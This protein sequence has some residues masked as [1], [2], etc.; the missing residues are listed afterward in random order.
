MRWFDVVTCPWNK[1][2]G[3]KSQGRYACATK[4]FGF[5]ETV[6]HHFSGKEFQDMMRSSADAAWGGVSQGGQAVKFHWRQAG[7]DMG[8]DSYKETGFYDVTVS[9]DGR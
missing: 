3:I 2:K 1:V 7:W 4:M 5:L 9:R 8:I 6:W